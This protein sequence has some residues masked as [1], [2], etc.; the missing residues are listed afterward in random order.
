VARMPP[1]LHDWG[2]NGIRNVLYKPGRRY[3]FPRR[4]T[5]FSRADSLIRDSTRDEVGFPG[6]RML[7]ATREEGFPEVM[8]DKFIEPGVS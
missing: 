7:P 8:R 3:S 4:G 5:L 6:H 2:W 1:G